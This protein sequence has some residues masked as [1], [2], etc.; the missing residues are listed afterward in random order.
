MQVLSKLKPTRILYISCNPISFVK[1]ANALSSDYKITKIK[2]LD[3][4]PYTE[5]IEMM[6][7]LERV[8]G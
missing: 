2:A 7:L 4:F 1:D 3:M 8:E 6:L 5:H